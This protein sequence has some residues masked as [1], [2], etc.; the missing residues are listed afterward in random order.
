MA[1]PQP[2]TAKLKVCLVGEFAVG[3]TSLIRR[4]VYDTFDD[5]YVAT[6]GAKVTKK[7]LQ[8]AVPD[9]HTHD[10]V[11][12]SIWDIMGNK[13]LRDLLKEAYFRGSQGIMAVCDVTRPETLSELEDWRSSIGKIEGDIPA[14]VVANKI[15][16]VEETK[17][18]PADVESFCEGWRCPY[19]LTSAKTGKGVDEAFLALATAILEAQLQRANIQVQ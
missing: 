11:V 13:G 16:L 3:K 14:Y 9:S 15:D 17:L 10:R 8:V 19:V 4:Y 7:E 5:R 1:F 6:L 18:S 2:Q 12:L